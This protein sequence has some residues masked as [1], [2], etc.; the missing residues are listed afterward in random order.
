MMLSGETSALHLCLQVQWWKRAC[1]FPFGSV[2]FL[3]KDRDC[4]VDLLVARSFLCV[5]YLFSCVD[6][7]LVARATVPSTF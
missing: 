5:E 7:C 6:V 2:C 3:P 1:L 4:T